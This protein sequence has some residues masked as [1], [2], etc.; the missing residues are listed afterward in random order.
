MRY[1]VLLRGVNVGGKHAVKM[2]ELEALLTGMAFTEVTTLLQSGNVALNSDLPEEALLARVRNAFAERFGFS[3]GLTARSA[4]EMGALVATQPFP[5]EAVARAE[6][7][8]P[9]TRHLYVYFLERA[10]EPEVLRRLFPPS[11]GDDLAVG[12]REIF[13]L[14]AG[15]VRSSATA[16]QLAA[17]FPAATARNWDTVEKLA[18]L[19]GKP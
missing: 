17:A 9:Q 1:A 4:A 16:L 19:T 2:A 5:P 8:D 11:E 12:A 15:S 13:L 18:A 10:P 7:A 3:C 14:C 6:A